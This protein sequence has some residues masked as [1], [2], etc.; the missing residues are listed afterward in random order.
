VTFDIKE[1]DFTQFVM[2]VMNSAIQVSHSSEA[3]SR[4][5]TVFEKFN[6]FN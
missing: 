1:G 4:S 5:R 6:E 3:D 2:K